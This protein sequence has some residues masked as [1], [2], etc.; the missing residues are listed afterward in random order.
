LLV[1]AIYG[2]R[3]MAGPWAQVAVGVIFYAVGDAIHWHLAEAG[4]YGPAGSLVT[5][6]FWTGGYLL[7]GLGAYCR[8]LVLTG[9]IK[10]AGAE[11]AVEN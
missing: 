5:A 7:V 6:L 3:G 10:P 2:G 1:I 11:A 8:R 9:I 4:L